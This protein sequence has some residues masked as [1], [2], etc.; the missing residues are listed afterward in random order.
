MD[1]TLINVVPATNINVLRDEQGQVL[2]GVEVV[3]RY[4]NSLPGKSVDPELNQIRLLKPLPK[5]QFCNPEVQP[6]RGAIQ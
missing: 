3:V 1:P 4:L 5:A 6:L 2:D